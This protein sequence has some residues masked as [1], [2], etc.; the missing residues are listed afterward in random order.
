M[1]FVKFSFEFNTTAQLLIEKSLGFV[2]KKSI[3]YDK[4]YF[5]S[6]VKKT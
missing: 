6:G 1:K 4:T 2:Q 5:T 3:H